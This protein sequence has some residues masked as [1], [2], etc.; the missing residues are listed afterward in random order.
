VAFIYFSLRV[1]CLI[2]FFLLWLDSPYCLVWRSLSD[3]THSVGTLRLSDQPVTQNSTWQHT[4]LTRDRYPCPCGIRTCNSSK[5][6][7]TDK[8]LR[9]RG[10]W[11]RPPNKVYIDMNLYGWL[12][13]GHADLFSWVGVR[14]SVKSEYHHCDEGEH[15]SLHFYQG[16]NNRVE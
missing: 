10:H 6:A 7:A 5:R 2:H 15:V 8:R 14:V 16:K 12:S 13:I 3:T 4:T 9:P 1:T 11:D